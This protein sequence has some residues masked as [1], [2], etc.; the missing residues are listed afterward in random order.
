VPAPQN[1]GR[2]LLG[3]IIS[4]EGAMAAFG[5]YSLGSGLWQGEPM[6][7]FWGVSILLGLAVLAAVRRRDWQN[8]WQRLEERRP[9]PPHDPG[10]PPA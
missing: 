6:P 8:H 2:P 1:P 9:A 5:L 10:A 4:L 7:V 3:R